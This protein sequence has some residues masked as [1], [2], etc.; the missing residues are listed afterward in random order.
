MKRSETTT[1]RSEALRDA[2]DRTIASGD[3]YL[4]SL[5]V[6]HGNLPGPRPNEEL[7]AAFGDEL[8]ARGAAA[9]RVIAELVGMDETRAR[10]TS[11]EAF[12]PYVGAHA[13]GARIAR[14][15]DERRSADALE[16]MAGDARKVVRDGVV[17]TLVRLAPKLDLPTRLASY[18]EGFLQAAVALEAMS[19]R[20]VLDRIADPT[21]LLERLDEATTLAEKAGRAAERTQ[22]RRR[23]L[24]VLGMTI[25]VFATRY[26]AVVAWVGGRAT[27][28]QPELRV[29][30]E[31]A[32]TALTRAGAP[33]ET[34]DTLR[35]ALD[36]SAAPRRDPT[37]YMG[38]TRGR[39][40]KANRRAE[41]K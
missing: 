16:E 15:Y 8:A 9:D 22:G 29:A 38:P 36:G 25:P 35:H 21:D 37:T 4:F 18:F 32:L 12:L 23:L 5:L 28:K 24:E 27:T 26:P 11:A 2:L 14:K 19:N 13:L 7:A 31:E 20:D 40:R 30:F 34:L 10:G 3:R 17:A 6:R 33:T 41:R 1:L 39:G